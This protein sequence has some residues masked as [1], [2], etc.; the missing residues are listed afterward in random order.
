MGERHNIEYKQVLNDK[1]E[2]EVVAFLNGKGG[3]KLIIGIDDS[4]NIVGLDEPEEDALKIKNRIINNIEPSTLGLFDI[5]NSERNRKHIIE[6]DLA[7]GPEKPYYIKKYGMSPKGAFIRS[8][9]A[10]EPMTQKLIE[11]LFSN[12][13]KNSLSKIKSEKQKLSFEK[14]KIYYSEKGKLLGEQFAHNLELLTEEGSY[15]Y[16]AY[17]LSDVNISSISVAVYDSNDRNELVSAV[18][19][20]NIC[21]ISSINKVLDRIEILNS[22]TT[23]IGRERNDEQIWEPDALRE[24]VNNAFVHNDYSQ[25]KFPKFEIFKDRME[26]TSAGGLAA[27]ISEKEFFKGYSSPRNNVLMRVFKDLDMVEQLGYGIPKVLKYYNK[28]SFHFSD[29]FLRVSLLKK[30][31]DYLEENIIERGQLEGISMSV[32]P[33]NRVKGFKSLSVTQI[34]VLYRI[35]KNPHITYNELA[36]SLKIKSQSTIQ[37]HISKLKKAGSIKRINGTRGQWEVIFKKSK[38]KV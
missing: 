25:G 3:G 20:G 18:D 15:N 26:I 1:L 21:L 12:R 32:Q 11:N 7:S 23:R 36:A 6:I 28:S 13:T 31:Y 8:S 17:L 2:K 4:G 24:L 9:S 29:N 38:D 5:R 33:I 22:T 37:K 35:L 34:N 30:S 14:L 16:N 27:N 10:A 19:Y